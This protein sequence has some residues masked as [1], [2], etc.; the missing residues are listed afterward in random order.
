L[1]I[2]P[3][4]ELQHVPATQ[5]PD[6]QSPGPP[7]DPPFLVLNEAVTFTLAVPIVTEQVRLPVGVQPLHDWKTPVEV[8]DAASCTTVPWLTT[9]EQTV[10]Q[11]IPIAGD[12]TLPAPMGPSTVT[13]RETWTGLQLGSVPDQFPSC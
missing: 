5:K 11:L 13:E 1:H 8:G 10:P 6:E 7:Q 3:Q 12:R 4:A 2:P 9:A